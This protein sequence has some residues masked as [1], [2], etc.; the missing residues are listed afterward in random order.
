VTAQSD[1]LVMLEGGTLARLGGYERTEAGDWR[2]R[3]LPPPLPRSSA[4]VEFGG[5]VRLDGWRV[6]G[7][8]VSPGSGVPLSFSWHTIQQ[9]VM[10]YSLF[11][12]L[13]DA[14]GNKVA[15]LDWQPHDAFGPRP[16]T[17]WR[18]SQNIVDEEILPL[19][20]DLPAGRYQLILGIYDW[21][22]GE[23]LPIAG[24]IARPDQTAQLAE[25]EVR[26]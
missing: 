25:I 1:Q 22:T 10:D 5:Q 6:D 3:N 18:I 24:S 11:V 14:A 2:R 13:L 9:P 4:S 8:K 19:S 12:H 15:Q 23:R 7:E 20:P 17:T 21:Q 16:M 26:N